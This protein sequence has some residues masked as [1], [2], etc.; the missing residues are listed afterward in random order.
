MSLC[1]GFRDFRES[2]FRAST[3]S[4]AGVSE[5]GTC[6]VLVP[7]KSCLSFGSPGLRPHTAL[8]NE[9]VSLHVEHRS[10][11]DLDQFS[12][13]PQMPPLSGYEGLSKVR[14]EARCLWRTADRGRNRGFNMA[15]TMVDSLDT[16]ARVIQ[17]WASGFGVWFL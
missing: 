6:V 7:Q 8:R 10:K 13:W 17:S 11:K 14:G 16:C 2:G 5:V 3:R 12:C 15:V 1:T 4:H 9:H